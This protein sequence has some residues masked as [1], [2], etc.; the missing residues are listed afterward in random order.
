MGEMERHTGVNGEH[1]TSPAS[2]ALKTIDKKGA[3]CHPRSISHHAY[4][5]K[6]PEQESK[7]TTYLM[8]LEENADRLHAAVVARLVVHV[9]L[10]RVGRHPISSLNA[11]V[12]TS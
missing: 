10:A 9:L 8:F 3:C 12:E 2:V 7:Y 1:C 4:V 5:R 11:C 6:Q